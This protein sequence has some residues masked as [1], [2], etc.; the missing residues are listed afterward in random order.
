M[1]ALISQKHWILLIVC[2]LFL[3]MAR[4]DSQDVMVQEEEEE[5][6]VDPDTSTWGTIQARILAPSCA[7]TCHKAGSSF[8]AQSDL[9]L[10]ADV[11][12]QQLIDRTP[13]NTAAQTDGLVLVRGNGVPDLHQSF[14][15][16]KINAPN[17]DHLF[18]EHPFYGSIMPLGGKV[19]TYGELSFIRDWILA[20]APE[21][22]EVADRALLVDT[23]RYAAG[24][25]QPLSPEPNTIH[26]ELGPFE[27]APQYEREMFYFETL[28]E[29]SDVLIDNIQISMRPGSHHFLLYSFD[30]DI[31]MET[32]PQPGQIRDIRNAAGQPILQ[33]MLPMLFHVFFAGTQWPRMNYRFPEGVALRMPEGIGLDLNSHYVNR[34]GETVVGEVHVNLHKAEPGS[35]LHEASVLNLNNADF[36]LPP[37]QVTTLEKTF[38]VD[39]RIH[40]FQLFSHA[41]EHMT[42][43]KVEVVGGPRD[44]ELVYYTTDW[45]HPPILELDPPLIL[46]AGQGLRTIATYD[47]TTNRTLKFGLLSVDEMMILFGYYY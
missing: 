26:L 43:F 40:I 44:G 45:Q 35:V 19:L 13:N 3:G 15:W 8:A 33:N 24:A 29:G 38:S 22:G 25:F 14:L 21:D 18:A 20:G 5:L 28:D 34:T 32:R 27:V 39:E 42:E 46:E 47:N 4:C 2:A 10:T 23:T 9:I 12:Y 16:E 31:P 6:V 17:E 36:E 37:N 1:I 30:Q 11:A 41:H 7:E